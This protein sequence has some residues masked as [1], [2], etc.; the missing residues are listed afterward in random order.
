MQ[1]YDAG[2][3]AMYSLLVPLFGMSSAVLLLG[4]RIGLTD[5]VAGCLIV[6]GVALG[7]LRRRA[8]APAH[9]TG[10]G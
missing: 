1:R 10:R 7:S 6:G 5:V 4:E 3:V 9:A 8:S 2:Q